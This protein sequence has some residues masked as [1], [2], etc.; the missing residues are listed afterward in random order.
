MNEPITDNQP[1]I[2]QRSHARLKRKILLW[3]GL[4]MLFQFWDSLLGVILHALHILIEYLELA[5][6][7]LLEILFHLE[8]HD[9]QMATAWIGSLLII[10]FLYR[11]ITRTLRAFKARF[12]SRGYFFAWLKVHALENWLFLSLLFAACLGSVLFM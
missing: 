10:A 2:P 4:Y 3:L 7:H 1:T 12:R 5:L 11:L 8:G 9:G 6:E